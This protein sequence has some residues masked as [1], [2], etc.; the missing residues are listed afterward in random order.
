MTAPVP[1]RYACAVCGTEYT[2]LRAAVECERDHEAREMDRLAG[3][4]EEDR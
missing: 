3:L 4:D 2:A 1:T